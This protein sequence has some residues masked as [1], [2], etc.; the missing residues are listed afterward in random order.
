MEN[1]Q[2]PAPPSHFQ[3]WLTFIEMIAVLVCLASNMV[4]LHSMKN[5][6]LKFWFLVSVSASSAFRGMSLLLIMEQPQGIWLDFLYTAPIL[7][8]IQSYIIF[9]G[10]LAICMSVLANKD[11]NIIQ[12]SIY[13]SPVC[14]VLS[15]VYFLIKD[16]FLERVLILQFLLYGALIIGCLYFSNKLFSDLEDDDWIIPFLS[17]VNKLIQTISISL[18]LR[19]L[20]FFLIFANYVQLNIDLILIEVFMGE[21]V[22]YY[23][24]TFFKIPPPKHDNDSRAGTQMELQN[25]EGPLMK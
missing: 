14:L 3:I 7:F 17:Q 23:A 4:K 24:L 12:Y 1:N 25:L 11:T 19:L 22:P 20:I 5:K 15:Y 16:G 10:H 8:W 2:E 21:L 9:I 6:N 13:Y 18:A